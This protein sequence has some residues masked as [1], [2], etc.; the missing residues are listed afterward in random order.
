MTTLYFS[1][2]ACSLAAHIVLI[3][4]ELPFTLEKVDL[5]SKQTVS[6]KDFSKITEKTYV[7]ALELDNGY[8]L[9]ENVAILQYVAD[10][11]PQK[12]LAPSFAQLERYQLIAWLNYIAT[13]LHKNFSPLFAKQASEEWLQQIRIVLQKKMAWLNEHL[14]HNDYLLAKQYTIADAYLWTVLRWCA[15]VGVDINALEF[16]LNYARRITARPAA[17]KALEAEGIKANF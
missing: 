15:F 2:G 5:R 16:L 8:V 17:Q 10:L 11:V 3:E 7:P 14:R 13:E 12:Q 9:T 4:A 1:P 6:G